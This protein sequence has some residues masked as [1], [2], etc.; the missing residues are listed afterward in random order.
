MGIATWQ[1]RKCLLNLTEYKHVL[2]VFIFAS[3]LTTL[4]L[5]YFNNLV[6]F[7]SKIYFDLDSPILE[8]SSTCYKKGFLMK[9]YV[10]IF[11][12]FLFVFASTASA[13]PLPWDVSA[14]EAQEV[15]NSH[16][17][18]VKSALAQGNISEDAMPIGGSA[19]RVGLP[20][21]YSDIYTIKLASCGP[22]ETS[23]CRIEGCVRIIRNY[24]SGTDEPQTTISANKK[25]EFE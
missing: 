3:R 10:Q 23:P 14:G 2:I 9:I 4:N 17:P 25:C 16:Q 13:T 7:G 19:L 5:F 8:A 1:I 24:Q 21:N 15:M 22:T 6:R 20:G 12:S 11:S 18:Q